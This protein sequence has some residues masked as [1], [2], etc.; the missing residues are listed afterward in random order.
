M[1]ANGDDLLQ[2]LA[3]LEAERAE[4]DTAIAVIRRKLG[5]QP[6]GVTG[7]VPQ[8]TLPQ[9]GQVRKGD[10][11][12]MTI[13]EATK[14]YLGIAMEPKT[15]KEIADALTLGGVHSKSADFGNIVRS[16][17]SRRG[18]EFGVES[19]GDGR[20]GLSDWRPGRRTSQNEESKD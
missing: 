15:P 11:L 12:G 1:N 20:W 6:N 7:A 14:K 17:L 2:L 9:S 18:K 10:F 16:T 4:L 5:K 19:F 13:P 8:K 3:E